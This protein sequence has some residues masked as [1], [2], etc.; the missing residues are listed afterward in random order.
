MFPDVQTMN[1]YINGGR[2]GAG[3]EGHRSGTGGAGGHGMGP[4]V[5][6]DIR[7]GGNF[8][9]NNVQQGERGIYILH[10]AVAIAAIHDSAESYPQPRCHPETRTQMLEDLRDWARDENA[11][12]SILWLHGPAGA[13]KTAIMQTLAKQLRDTGRLGGSFFFKRGHSAR[14][15]ANMLFATIAYQLALSVPWLRTAIAGVVE[16]DPSILA[17]SLETQLRKLIVKPCLPHA[18]RDFVTILIDGLDE[19]EGHN[20][21][22]DILRAIRKSSKHALP[23]RFIVASRPEPHIRE[24]FNSRSYSGRFRSL[25]VEQSSH[26][27]RKYLCDGFSRIHRQHRTMRNIREVAVSHQINWWLIF[28][29]DSPSSRASSATISSS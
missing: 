3:G 29:C 21:Q 13:G 17:R 8:T 1:N 27:V 20:M 11:E 15:N 23:L 22:E 12:H 4:S 28:L 7:S 10:R 19:C 18:D 26:D 24:V 9:M 25:N 5:N 2:G 6:F 14:G 16:S